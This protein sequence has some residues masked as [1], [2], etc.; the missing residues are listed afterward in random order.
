MSVA[1]TAP[2]VV[3][4][5]VKPLA[6]MAAAALEQ[7]AKSAS[8]SDEPAASFTG[9]GLPLISDFR[10]TAAPPTS[11]HS[12]SSLLN[13]EQDTIVTPFD[14][15]AKSGAA[16]GSAVGAPGKAPGPP[17]PTKAP[18][19]VSNT[20]IGGGIAPPP[21]SLASEDDDLNNDET[22]ASA[23]GGEGSFDASG[24][25]LPSAGAR[26]PVVSATLM[27]PSHPMPQSVAPVFAPLSQLPLPTPVNPVYM[28]A[29]SPPAPQQYR[30]VG[31][32]PGVNARVVT[33]PPPGFHV[34]LSL[35][36]Q[37]PPGFVT[38]KAMPYGAP[39]GLPLPPQDVRQPTVAPASSAE[40]AFMDRFL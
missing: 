3:V 1:V 18:G 31:P 12:L 4:E 22:F 37:A 33:P 25:F 10:P 11:Q 30:A 15:K 29:A 5:T 21:S 35:P 26:E 9:F 13:T 19:P 32:P 24:Q 17:A 36:L 6:A 23:F 7:P 20:P 14:R 34:P 40:A 16:I 39:L 2:P 28:R 27:P 8:T 38:A